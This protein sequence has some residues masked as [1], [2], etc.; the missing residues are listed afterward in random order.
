MPKLLALVPSERAIVAKDD[1]SVSLISVVSGFTVEIR[2]DQVGYTLMQTRQ[3]SIFTLWRREAGEDAAAGWEQRTEF[4]S[5]SGETQ[6]VLV[7]IFAMPGTT[8]AEV[9]R[10]AVLPIPNLTAGD[11]TFTIRV[12]IRPVSG[13]AYEQAG[14]FPL[15]VTVVVEGTPAEVQN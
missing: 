10:V 2:P 4:V 3:W 7:K 15:T 12:A 9:D 11:H 14:E 5:P 8:H 6:F 1:N 13:A